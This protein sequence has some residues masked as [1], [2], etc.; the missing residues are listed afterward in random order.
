M[1]NATEETKANDVK[2]GAISYLKETRDANGK[3]LKV[4][5]KIKATRKIEPGEV[6]GVYVPW[7]NP[8]II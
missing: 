2:I 5:V 7:V 3:I 6:Y 8:C 4:D 1:D